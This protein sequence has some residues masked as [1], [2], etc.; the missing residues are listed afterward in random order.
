MASHWMSVA[1]CHWLGFCWVRRKVF[2]PP[3]RVCEG[4]L[5]LLG[6]RRCISSWESLPMGV[7]V[8]ERSLCRAPRLNLSEIA[9]TRFHIS[10]FRSGFFLKNIADQELDFLRLVV[11]FLSARQVL[12]GLSYP[13]SEESAQIG[14]C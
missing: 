3:A 13:M 6:E 11:L 9:F 5:L 4:K 2:L 10:S 7:V 8:H 12:S 14:N 1:V